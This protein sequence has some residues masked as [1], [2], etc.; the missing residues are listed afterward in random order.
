MNLDES[1]AYLAK[2]F[3]CN[4]DEAVI[5]AIFCTNL[6]ERFFEEGC[7]LFILR[8]DGQQVE[9]SRKNGSGDD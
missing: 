6:M 9:W 4:E 8:P 1:I 2:R 5:K 3:D 7:R